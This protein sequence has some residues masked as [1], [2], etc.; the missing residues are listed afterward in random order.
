VSKL[1]GNAIS[2]SGPR[3]TSRRARQADPATVTL[4]FADVGTASRRP[5][6]RTF[7]RASP[8][9]GAMK[10]GGRHLARLH[11]R[12]R[13]PATA[14]GS[15]RA[16]AGQGS[17][18]IVQLPVVEQQVAARWAESSSSMTS[19]IGRWSSPTRGR[20]QYDVD[21]SRTAKRRLSG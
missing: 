16:T 14:E 7:S 10:C 12:P 17:T 21:L 19:S 20:E 18:F 15:R 5:S 13:G 3:C 8:Y 9:S 4:R 2:Y 6:G 1:V 11:V